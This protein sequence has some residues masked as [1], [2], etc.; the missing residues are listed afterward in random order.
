[1]SASYRPVPVWM[2]MQLVL[3]QTREFP[4]RL[5]AGKLTSSSLRL[6]EIARRSLFIVRRRPGGV[7]KSL[8]IWWKEFL[9]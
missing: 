9:K 1:M 4:K 3:D 8:L 5:P 7:G 6:D 2:Q